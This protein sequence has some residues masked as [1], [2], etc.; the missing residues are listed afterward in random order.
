MKF[1][2]DANVEYHLAT[3]LFSHRHDVKTIARDYPHS[4]ADRDVLS[5][6]AQKKRILVTNDRDF[7]ELIFRQHL[8]HSGVILFRMKNSNDLTDKIRW[9]ETV[10]KNYKDSLYDSYLVITSHGVWIRKRTPYRL[11]CNDVR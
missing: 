5:L 11:L 1:L 4:L 3:F 10:I 9:L 6:A 2:L 7:G 8:P